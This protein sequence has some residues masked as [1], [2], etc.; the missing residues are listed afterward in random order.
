MLFFSM[1]YLFYLPKLYNVKYVAY[2]ENTQHYH[3]RA[4]KNTSV[5]L[6]WSNYWVREETKL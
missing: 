3:E 6:C 4:K 5:L 2:N 1:S